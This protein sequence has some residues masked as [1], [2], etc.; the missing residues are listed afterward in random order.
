MGPRA[1]LEGSGK[2]RPRGA[3]ISGPSS[4]QRVAIPTELSRPTNI[5]RVSP[6][7]NARDIWLPE[8]S[9]DF[10]VTRLFCAV[11]DRGWDGKWAKH[12]GASLKY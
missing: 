1:G 3:S 12:N 7:F 2:S 10:E 9:G 4:P 5:F 6:K 11:R 8:R